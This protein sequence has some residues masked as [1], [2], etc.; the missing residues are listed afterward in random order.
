MQATIPFEQ[1]PYSE[2]KPKLL[3]THLIIDDRG[4]IVATYDKTHLFDLDIAGKI[5]LCES[6]YVI[7]GSKIVAPVCTPVGRV[8]LATVS[9]SSASWS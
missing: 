5:R 7:P 2:E 3:N 9:F 6:D 1:G 4:K 8:G